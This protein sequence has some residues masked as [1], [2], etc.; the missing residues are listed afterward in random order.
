[1]YDFV[2]QLI[3]YFDRPHTSAAVGPVGGNAAWMGSDLADSNAWCETLSPDQAD[4]LVAAVAAARAATTSLTALA[5][6]DFPL[7]DRKSVV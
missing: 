4:E 5:A 7:P 6:A 2:E 3:H 1:M